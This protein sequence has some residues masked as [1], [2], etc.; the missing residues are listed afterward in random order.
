MA[1]VSTYLITIAL[2]FIVTNCC[3]PWTLATDQNLICDPGQFQYKYQLNSNTYYLS[4]QTSHLWSWNAYTQANGN[5]QYT[6]NGGTSFSSFGCNGG[7]SVGFGVG[8]STG[9]GNKWKVI[10]AYSQ[11][12]NL[13]TATVCQ[14]Q[15]GIFGSS[16]VA[17]IEI[18]FRSCPG[19]CT[20]SPS[21]YPTL[22]PS[23]VPTD[24]PSYYPSY[25]PT[26]SPSRVPTDNP[27]YYP[28]YYP[29]LSPTYKN[30][31]DEGEIKNIDWDELQN[32]NDNSAQIPYHD[33]TINT[34]QNT[35][36]LTIDINL[37]YV[38]FSSD[39]NFDK[40]YNLGTTYVIDW[41]SFSVNGD[42]I[43]KPGTCQNRLKS[44]FNDVTDFSRF[45]GFSE[46]PYLPDQL[47]SNSYL[48]YPPSQ[49]WTLSIDNDVCTPINYNAVFSWKA[50]SE[51]TDFEGNQ[52]IH[53]VDGDTSISLSGTLYVNLVSPYSM[54]ATDTGIYRTFP[55]IQQ[56]FEISI[57][58]QI[59][60][61]SST[62]VQ[63]FIV[64]IIS[65]YQDEMDGSMGISVLTQS[66]DYI[67]LINPN[68]ISSPLNGTTITSVASSCL[69]A[70]SYTCGQIFTVRV[71]ESQINCPPA[72]LSGDYTLQ[73]EVSCPSNEEACNTF[74]DDNGGPIIALQVTSNFI[75]TTCEPELYN[76]IF[77]GNIEFYDDPEFNT[78]HDDSSSYVIGQDTVYVQVE[79][80]F[81]DDG[82]DNNFNIFGV[83]I[84][85]VYVCTA[86]N[87]IDLT[88]NVDQQ[89]GTGAC[90]SSNI[91]PDGPYD[92][93]TNGLANSN[94]MA[95]II[96]ST[97][98]SNIVQFSFLTF[99][100]G[101][102]VM[103]A[104]VQLTLILQN[105]NRRRLELSQVANNQLK[106]NNYIDVSDQIRHFVDSTGIKP[107]T[108]TLESTMGGEVD[109]AKNLSLCLSIF[110]CFVTFILY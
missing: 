48:S 37:E 49:Y 109:Y 50:L 102:T 75:D 1:T 62:G 25:Y 76:I 20:K 97:G 3:G 15:P 68:I 33:F 39:G 99:D 28:S 29:T 70:S 4:P 24:N 107:L 60:V 92:I 95:Q 7:E 34:N 17:N 63:L 32:N 94:Y 104:H 98:D 45:W 38:G 12:K 6:T 81:P 82:T 74:I 36:E 9:G 22:S 101:R 44:S 73:F 51:C 19:T 108:S 71:D 89:N 5:Y 67:Q 31:N 86:D 57:L 85:N 79:V 83:V 65:V 93:I 27:S 42:N 26:L 58:K 96:S 66:A 90:L 16:C 14:D 64:S 43:D 54:D 52:L 41:Q 91:D 10:A 56:D 105:G 78:L 30:C 18:Y 87:D 46:Y 61:L 103:Y 8:C 55:L 110:V 35:L 13:A 21:Y 40:N 53:V 100:V 106:D 11:N 77:D 69:V 23:R 88:V 84:D 2:F 80:N 72:D 47:S 59:N